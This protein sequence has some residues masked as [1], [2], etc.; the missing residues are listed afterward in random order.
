[1]A[2]FSSLVNSECILKK[3]VPIPVLR[4]S[5]F[6]SQQDRSL[7]LPKYIF[8]DFN[9]TDTW[10][11]H[12]I[13]YIN[14]Y[15]LKSILL[16]WNFTTSGLGKCFL[17]FFMSFPSRQWILSELLFDLPSKLCKQFMLTNKRVNVKIIDHRVVKTVL[18]NLQ[19]W[20]SVRGILTDLTEINRSDCAQPIQ[21]AKYR[22]NISVLLKI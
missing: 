21:Q 19:I 17:D 9:M 7:I 22:D 20:E 13:I 10:Q 14:L 4:G 16:P 8:G 6:R 3:N 15:N 5:L 11:I 12:R 1:M 2:T 18:P